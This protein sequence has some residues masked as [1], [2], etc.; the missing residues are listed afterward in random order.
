MT[1]LS[2]IRLA[3]IDPV[4][5][6]AQERINYCHVRAPCPS[7]QTESRKQT[8][9]GHWSLFMHAHLLVHKQAHRGYIYAQYKIIAL[10]PSQIDTDLS[11]GR[12]HHRP[13][14]LLL[15]AVNCTTYI[16]WSQQVDYPLWSGYYR[17]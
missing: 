8:R 13:K 17:S 12:A 4:H 1:F 9:D 10:L 11:V 15:I 6:V 2:H 16:I 7:P 5:N 14:S 3:R